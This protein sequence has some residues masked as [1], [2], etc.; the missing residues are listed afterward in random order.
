MDN[1]EIAKLIRS[2]EFLKYCDNNRIELVTMDHLTDFIEM[3]KHEAS[4]AGML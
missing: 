2:E 1:E 3:Q 4:G